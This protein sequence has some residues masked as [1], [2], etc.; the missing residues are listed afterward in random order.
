MPSYSKSAELRG[1][2]SRDEQILTLC[3]GRE[4]SGGQL[5]QRFSRQKETSLK[6]Q[7]WPF[8]L[9]GVMAKQWNLKKNEKKK[10]TAPTFGHM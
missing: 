6:F 2:E 8:W 3:G 4:N 1:I 7:C 10:G 5:E 9:N